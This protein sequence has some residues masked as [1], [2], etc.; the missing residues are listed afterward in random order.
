[1]TGVKAGGVQRS[2]WSARCEPQA[3]LS[4]ASL[5]IVGARISKS[6]QALPQP[7]DLQ[8]LSAPLAVG[9]RGLQLQVGEVLR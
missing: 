3:R 9:T 1:L 6:G 2:R 7:G 4:G 5:V 8:V